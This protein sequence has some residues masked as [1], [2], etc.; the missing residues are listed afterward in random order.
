MKISVQTIRITG[1]NTENPS[2][3]FMPADSFAPFAVAK[4]QIIPAMN[5]PDAQP[6]SPAS[7]I[8]LYIPVPPDLYFAAASENVPGHITATDNPQSAQAASDN[9]GI[10]EKATVM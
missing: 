8:R 7:A 10:S 5:G 4:L 9:A 1:N 6:R 3:V 2:P